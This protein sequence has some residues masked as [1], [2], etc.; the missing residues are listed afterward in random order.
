VQLTVDVRSGGE[1]IFRPVGRI[2][3][4]SSGDI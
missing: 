3:L 4:G 2:D 1:A